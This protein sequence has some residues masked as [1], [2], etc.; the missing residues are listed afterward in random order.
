MQRPA[1]KV[2]LA[3]APQQAGLQDQHNEQEVA[4]LSV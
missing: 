2:V 3:G 1:G 4:G